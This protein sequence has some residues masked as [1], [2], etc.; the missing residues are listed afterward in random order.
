[1]R[2]TKTVHLIRHGTS[3]FNVA[4]A[5]APWIDPMLFDARLSP[6]GEE[7]AAALRRAAAALGVE[8]AVTSPLTR[9][10]QTAVAAFGDLAPIRVESLHCERVETSCDIGRSP[11]A[12]AAE[13]PMLA[14]DHLDDPWWH[15]D[16]SHP[17]A[18]VPEPDAVLDRR[19]AAFRDWLGRRPE[20]RIAVI[21]HGTFFQRLTGRR[22]ANAEILSLALDPDTLDFRVPAEGT[23]E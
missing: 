22:L 3:T 21:G 9:A 20:R 11:A 16:G 17:L 12:L 18:I 10:I 8:L 7:Q 1:M 6:R 14:F 4:C 5:E 13:F 2:M 23:A 19:I 15:T